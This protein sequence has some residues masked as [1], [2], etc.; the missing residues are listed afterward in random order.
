MKG[1]NVVTCSTTCGFL[2][3]VL[4]WH[5]MD[6]PPLKIKSNQTAGVAGVAFTFAFA[7]A[8]IGR[9]FLDS[10]FQSVDI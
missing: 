3:S 7:T 6:L 5:L 2:A 1:Q 4:L 10:V 8:T 9:I